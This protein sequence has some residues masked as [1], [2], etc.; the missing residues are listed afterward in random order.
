MCNSIQV[1]D[2]IALRALRFIRKKIERTNVFM[3]SNYTGVKICDVAPLIEKLKDAGY[4]K[5]AS[6]NCEEP[7]SPFAEYDIDEKLIM[8]IDLLLKEDEENSL[9]SINEAECANDDL[10]AKISV[11]MKCLITYQEGKT[12]CRTCLGDLAAIDMPIF[13]IIMDLNRKG[14][15]TLHCCSGHENSIGSYL[16][17][18]V[19]LNPPVIPNGFTIK[20]EKGNTEIRSIPYHKRG[21]NKRKTKETLDI[22]TIQNFVKQDMQSLRAWVRGLPTILKS[23]GGLNVEF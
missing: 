5:L 2:E 22:A 17:L 23:S 16:V 3:I 19:V 20:V 15:R 8:E 18:S 13:D 14:Y 6:R 4:I 11:C 7:Y 21:D 12:F 10:E 1:S 9:V